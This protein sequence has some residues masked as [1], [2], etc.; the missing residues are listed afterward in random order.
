MGDAE[1]RAE[2]S[3]F[4]LVSHAEI[5]KVGHHSSS[6]ASS[7]EFLNI[8]KPDIAIYMAGA[9]N[10]WDH[11]HQETIDALKKVGAKVYGTDTFGTIRITTDGKTPSVQTA[12]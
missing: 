7:L 4:N 5:L 12:K 2:D 1:R 3:M 6:S 11:P 8:I 10:Q 9:G